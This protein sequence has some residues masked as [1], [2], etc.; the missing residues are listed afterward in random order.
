MRDLLPLLPRPSRYA[1]IEDGAVRKHADSVRLRVALAFPDLYEVGMSYLGQKILY[2]IVNAREAWW[3]E[4]VMA[5][6]RAAA[7]ILREHGAP[8]S[9][10]ESDTPLARMDCV[11]F[12]ITHELCYTNVLYML[13]LAGI[14]LRH[15]DRPESLDACPL[16]MAGG[17]AL[18]GAEPLAPF[19][20][21]MVL[22]DGEE[23][24]PEVLELLERARAEGWGRSR[25][26]E[27]AR[28]I[29]GVY[30][31]SFFSAGP[32]GRLIPRFADH[33]RPARRIVADLEAAIYPARQVIPVGAVHNRLSLEIA[34]GC[35]RGCRFCHAGM[36]YRPVR[37]RSPES[38]S[39][40]ME[41]CLSETG[42][43]EISF[44]SLST[45][46]YSAL[47]TL[48]GATLDSCAREQVTLSLP[49]LRVGSIDD[50]IMGRMAELRRTGVTLAPEAGS[51]RLRDVINKGVSE[52]DILLHA[53]K[54]LEH[55]WRLV[56]LYFMIGLPTETDED[57]VAIAD[58]C[59]KVRDAAGR[60]GPRLQVTASL[61][62]FV[63]K[64]FTPF[65]WEPQIGLPEID[66]RVRLVREQFKGQK[67]LKLRWHEPAMSHLEGILSRGGREMADVVEL[68][69]R[70]GALF[71][72]WM[73][74]FDI[75]PWLEAL[76]EC[77]ISAGECIGGR[78]P[79]AA[80]PW[81]HLEAGVSEA[82]LL[83][84]R[85]RA[86]AGK[87]TPD[88]RYGACRQCGACDTA[89]GPSLLAGGEKVAAG[90]EAAHR[91]RL[92]FSQRDQAAH[93]PRRD[94]EG[95][96]ICKSERQEPPHLPPE[97]IHKAAE[98]RFWHT[99]NG[100]CACL[101][102]LEL[103]ATLERALRRAAMPLAFSRG[104]HP[105]PLLSFGRALPV[106]VESDA[107]WFALTLRRIVAPGEAAERLAPYLPPGMRLRLVEFTTPGKRTEQAVAEVFSL[108]LA[109]DGPD[110]PDST[111]DLLAQ[112]MAAF[113]AL[114][115]APFIRE[116]KKGPKSMDIRPLLLRWSPVARPRGGV[117]FTLDWTMGYLSPLAFVLAL[118]GPDGEDARLRA[119]LR[120][121]K[122]GQIFADGSIFPLEAGTAGA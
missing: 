20:D 49:S 36:V 54:L 116:G 63:P 102:Q 59:R 27:A 99:K 37:E 86:L 72:S 34:R 7:D 122:T 87:V 50:E 52:E 61:S 48:C 62:P 79:G 28:H 75:A 67:G 1:G 31:P 11:A 38:V 13:D 77:G 5:P 68:A 103:Q 100:G 107:E 17:G 110:G 8:L 25:F 10:L 76:A 2:G 84:E 91:N 18:L 95:R 93:Q 21:L 15:A 40:L 73:E 113:A 109:G 105:L 118:L 78:E 101:S 14:P 35:T 45:G 9:T 60:G 46:D 85:E 94:A 57:L 4:R 66:R 106:G 55:G 115:E 42:F 97:L 120:L 71:D 65:Q 92:V 23:T 44:L 104:F 32:E 90:A 47:K 51:Q 82:F 53:Q 39:S 64:P 121:R 108:H 3:A 81:G 22:G 26:L 117:T 69:W 29:G 12:S 96:L 114:A 43:E 41:A 33:A 80:L 74:H 16:V 19:M 111:D 89:A 88:C 98:Y 30:V 24:L 6:D 70:K 83:R 112:R 56:K 58:L 119:R